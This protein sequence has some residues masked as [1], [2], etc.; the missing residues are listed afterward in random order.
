METPLLI[1]FPQSNWMLCASLL[2]MQLKKV[3]QQG[4]PMEICELV[5]QLQQP[6]PLVSLNKVDLAH[7]LHIMQRVLP[8][9]GALPTRVAQSRLL[10]GGRGV[11]P[12][13]GSRGRGV[14]PDGRH[15]A[16][17]VGD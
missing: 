11:S 15:V 4:R 7:I 9:G 14:T 13:T 10:V 5:M 3:F 1:I 16:R 2:I 8:A 17:W 6:R 12:D